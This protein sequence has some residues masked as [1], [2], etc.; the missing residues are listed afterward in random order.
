RIS[1]P[2]S[3]TLSAA[4]RGNGGSGTNRKITQDRRMPV[5]VHK[6]ERTCHVEEPATN[7][8]HHPGIGCYGAWPHGPAIRQLRRQLA[9]CARWG[10]C[11]HSGYLSERR[12]P[13]G[14]R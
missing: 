13:A 6:R 2:A 14:G 10:S 8:R 4:R 1:T 5:R 7:R 11:T 12:I 3:A 9:A